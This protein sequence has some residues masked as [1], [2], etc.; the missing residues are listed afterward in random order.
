MVVGWRASR[1]WR[2][3]KVDGKKKRDDEAKKKQ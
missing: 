2:G 3:V 1:S